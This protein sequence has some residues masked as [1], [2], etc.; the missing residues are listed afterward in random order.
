M[1][2]ESW[3]ML[4]KLLE[5]EWLVVIPGLFSALAAVVVAAWAVLHFHYKER[6]DRKDEQIRAKESQIGLKAG[7]IEQ[8]DRKVADYNGRLGV[9]TPEE[10]QAKLQ[11]LSAKLAVH[12]ASGERRIEL[13]SFRSEI[14]VPAEDAKVTPPIEVS[15]ECLSMPPD[16]YE[17][18]LFWLSHQRDRWWPHQKLFPS[19]KGIG[20]EWSSTMKV[21]QWT[22]GDE[23]LF[24][25]FL[26]GPEGRCLVKHFKH[27]G[28]EISKHANVGWPA[29][30]E[31][32][33]DIIAV[34]A[35]RTV[36]IDV[37]PPGASAGPVA[38]AAA[39]R[40]TARA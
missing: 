18:W 8:L 12:P 34:G 35:V 24:Q 1:K 11:S 33:S 20:F 7:Q 19:Q 31:L 38:N 32:T 17:L 6:L 13:T 40:E 22:R 4:V 23:R 25:A 28:Q 36:T 37:D 2:P 39:G 9:T 29:L 3:Q 30:Q 15:G 21:T 5:S 14:T 26:V 27:A 10:A 16:G